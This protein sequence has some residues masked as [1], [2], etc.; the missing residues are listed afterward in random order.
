MS[1][2]VI[3]KRMLADQ[4]VNSQIF[5]TPNYYFGGR[6][7]SV[8]EASVCVTFYRVV[9]LIC[10]VMGCTASSA[11]VIEDFRHRLDLRM[12]LF[13]SIYCFGWAML[14]PKPGHMPRQQ[15]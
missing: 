6:F 1:L 14:Q 5:G 7:V 3:V 15:Q 2:Y 13:N 9:F 4:H 12:V 8:F 10:I 11:Y